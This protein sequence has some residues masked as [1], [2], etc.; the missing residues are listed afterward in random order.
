M[1]TLFAVP[2]PVLVYIYLPENFYT[3]VL[4]VCICVLSSAVAIYY[5]GCNA[6]ERTIIVSAINKIKNKIH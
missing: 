5:I 3:F 2:I 6:N 4:N 1:V